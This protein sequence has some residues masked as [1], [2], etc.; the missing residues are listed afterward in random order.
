[1]WRLPHS[2]RCW[3][4]WWTGCLDATR[5]HLK[6]LRGEWLLGCDHAFNTSW[7]NLKVR[8]DCPLSII[9]TPCW[10]ISP[11]VIVKGFKNCCGCVLLLY[12]PV[13]T[14]FQYCYCQVYNTGWFK[15]SYSWAVGL[16]ILQCGAHSFPTVAFLTSNFMSR[17]FF[18]CREKPVFADHWMWHV[19]IKC[20]YI[21]FLNYNY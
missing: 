21:Y 5:D 15:I 8:C 3:I 14:S 4:M 16:L 10:H 9:I 19:V 1:M 18:Y 11:E 2:C 13:P 17:M 12:L 20:I 7:K 6:Q